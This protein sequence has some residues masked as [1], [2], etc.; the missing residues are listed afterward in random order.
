MVARDETGRHC[1]LDGPPD[2]AEFPLRSIRGGD[3]AFLTGWSGQ[4]EGRHVPAIIDAH[5]KN[6]YRRQS[7]KREGATTGVS[8]SINYSSRAFVSVR[9]VLSNHQVERSA[10]L[11]VAYLVPKEAG[12]VAGG[13]YLP[14]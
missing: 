7:P 4:M 11:S 5:V 9:T 1:V 14:P 10:P 13:W 6:R 8:L 12:A 2:A 3:P